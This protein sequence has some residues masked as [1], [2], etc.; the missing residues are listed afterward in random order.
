MT[1]AR[2]AAF[3]PRYGNECNGELEPLDEG[4]W[5]CPNC[6]DLDPSIDGTRCDACGTI[7]ENWG[8]DNLVCPRCIEQADEA[9][10]ALAYAFDGQIRL[11][12]YAGSRSGQ[13]VTIALTAT[14]ALILGASLI[15]YAIAGDP[16]LAQVARVTHGETDWSRKLRA[17][18]D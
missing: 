16:R 8:G 5:R 14:E 10:L 6:G 13:E 11:H 3:D 7:E 2:C 4:G 17:H 1:Y 12:A 9:P 18:F 15:N